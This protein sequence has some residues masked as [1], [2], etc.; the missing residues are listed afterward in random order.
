MTIALTW[1]A[2]QES[3]NPFAPR[4]VIT[5]TGSPERIVVQCFMKSRKKNT[6]NLCVYIPKY[7]GYNDA[8]Q[9]Q[10]VPGID[11]LITLECVKNIG[12]IITKPPRTWTLITSPPDTGDPCAIPPA[13]PQ[14]LY[15]QSYTDKQD[16][17]VQN[18][19]IFQDT[20]PALAIYYH[21]IRIL[22]ILT[23]PVFI[24]TATIAAYKEKFD[25]LLIQTTD[26][27]QTLLLRNA[28]RPQ[29]TIML[30]PG[31]LD[32]ALA[33]MKNILVPKQ[34]DFEFTIRKNAKKQLVVK[35]E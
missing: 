15:T 30:N 28:L 32:S 7:T 23:L 5:V 27:K 12:D 14:P 13:W 16:V 4:P 24:D 2:K 1:Y 11:N 25:L 29:Y 17:T 33:V 34:A 19:R 10:E 6:N 31:I 35:E 20:I 8:R 21:R 22:L 26:N 9:T 18:A 3:N